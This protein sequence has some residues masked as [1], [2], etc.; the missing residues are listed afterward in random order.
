MSRLHRRLQSLRSD[1]L[2]VAAFALAVRILLDRCGFLIV[3]FSVV[4]SSLECV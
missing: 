4:F 1:L 3:L 2:E